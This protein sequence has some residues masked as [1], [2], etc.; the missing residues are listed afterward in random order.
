MINAKVICDSI[1]SNGVRLTT[2][3]LQFHRFILAEFNTHR[4]FSRSASSSRA[5]PVDKM[6]KQMQENPAM[7]I[8]WGKNQPGMQAKD[9]CNNLVT[10]DWDYYNDCE[11]TGT[12]ELAWKEAAENAAS[13]ARAFEFAGYH[14]Q[15]VNRLLEP[16]QWIKVI[17]TATEWENFFK[18]RLHKA[19]QPEIRVLAEH[20][21]KA[22]DESIP[23]LLKDGEWHLPYISVEDC[24]KT[25]TDNF[26][27][28]SVARCARVSYLNHD[29][30]I[31]N[32]EKDIALAD[33]LLED[34]HMSPFEHVAT[35]MSQASFTVYAEEGITHRDKYDILW[36]GNFRSWIMYRN[37]LNT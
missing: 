34:G 28:L 26:V 3:E 11:C 18:L 32:I 16:F 35:P 1:N 9:E 10:M 30:S 33:R 19:A 21:K 7:P 2:M 12:R 5:I 17:V 36:S 25:T 24:I 8:H 13:K 31:P 23:K 14:K 22:M 4:M 27:K 6:L 20:M 15:I 37:L 29:N